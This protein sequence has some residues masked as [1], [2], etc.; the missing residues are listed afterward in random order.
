MIGLWLLGP[1]SS[2]RLK[3]A[4]TLACLNFEGYIPVSIDRAITAVVVWATS[5]GRLPF[6]KEGHT[7]PLI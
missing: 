6:K 5:G 2:A 7:Q 3:T 4:I 1:N